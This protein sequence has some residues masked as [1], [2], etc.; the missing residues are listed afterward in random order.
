MKVNFKKKYE[1]LEKNIYDN[2]KKVSINSHIKIFYGISNDGH[3]RLSFLS[4]IVP[5]QIESTKSLRVIQGKEGENVFWTCIDLINNEFKKIFYFFCEDLINA[6]SE[7]KNEIEELNII[8]DRF[9]IWKTMFKKAKNS[10]SLEREQGLF[11]ELYFMLNYMIPKYGLEIAINSWAGPNGYNKDFSLEND[12][13]EIKTPSVNS[14]SIK[15]SSLNQLS[16][17]I[18]GRLAIVKVE[19]MSNEYAGE[20]SD[21]LSLIENISNIINSLELKQ[22]F[23]TKVSEYGF[24]EENNFINYKFNVHNVYLYKV[25]D[26]FPRLRETDIKF[27]EIGNV[28]YELFINTLDKYKVEEL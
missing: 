26:K 14:D 27:Q 7:A 17:E 6:I 5:P 24:S 23:L 22:E 16:S 21:V 9:Y 8:K 19:K 4:S 1:E 3:F 2:Q 28:Q 12:W 25:N 10:M 15:I 13:I 11:G 20:T 18:T